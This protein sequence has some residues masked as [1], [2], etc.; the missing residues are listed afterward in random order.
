[1]NEFGIDSLSLSQYMAVTPTMISAIDFAILKW[2]TSSAGPNQVNTPAYFNQ[3]MATGAYVVSNTQAIQAAGKPVGDYF[4]SYAWN[5]ASAEYEAQITCEHLLSLSVQP[6][7]PVFLDWEST[8]YWDY[9][10][11]AYEALINAGITPTSAIVQEVCDAWLTKVQSY[12]F[13]AGLYT[14]GSLASSLFTNAYL[15]DRRTNRN[16]FYW[17]ATWGA[18]N[19]LACDVWQYAGDQAW[20]GTVVDYDR[21]LDDRIWQGGGSNIPLWLKLYLGNRGDPHGKRTILL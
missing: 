21:V 6:D 4:F 9:R 12:G 16:L 7:W 13:R 14:S 5:A 17:E 11:G 18:S 3:T 10:M 19:M 15:Q 1:M 8:G 20:N 2:G